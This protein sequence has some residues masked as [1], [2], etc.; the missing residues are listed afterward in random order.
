[1][2]DTLFEPCLFDYFIDKFKV[3]FIFIGKFQGIKNLPV[4]DKLLRF[5]RIFIVFIHNNHH[6]LSGNKQFIKNHLIN[7]RCLNRRK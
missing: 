2:I 4:I 7:L 3:I 1:M 5:Q 6:S